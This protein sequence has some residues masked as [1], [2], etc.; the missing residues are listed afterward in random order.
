MLK[1]DKVDVGDDDDEGV[2]QQL[3]AFKIK[4]IKNKKIIIKPIHLG[5]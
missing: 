2:G 3:K 1:T 5:N 4:N